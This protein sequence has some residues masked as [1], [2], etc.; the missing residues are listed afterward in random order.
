MQ[1]AKNEPLHICLKSAEDVVPFNSS[2]RS[3]KQLYDVSYATNYKTASFDV[4]DDECT[5][6]TPGEPHKGRTDAYVGMFFITNERLA[7][8]DFTIPFLSNKGLSIGL[9][10]SCKDVIAKGG[11]F[12]NQSKLFAPF[13]SDLWYRIFFFLLLTCVLLM[14]VEASNKSHV[15]RILV[16][17]ESELKPHVQNKINEDGSGFTEKPIAEEVPHGYLTVQGIHE[18]FLY[19]FFRTFQSILAGNELPEVLTPEGRVINIW[20]ALCSVVILAAY[21]AN[22][23]VFLIAEEPHSIESISDLIDQGIE[24]YLPTDS[25]FSDWVTAAYPPG[26]GKSGLRVIDVPNFETQVTKSLNSKTCKAGEGRVRQGD[27]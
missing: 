13:N 2:L 10:E 5:D 4:F 22:L 26:G 11:S 15:G 20:L 9:P 21:T 7:K 8:N 6:K 23:T 25:A 14:F 27:S 24:T 16:K 19:Y 18:H 12:L 3:S 1:V 17:S